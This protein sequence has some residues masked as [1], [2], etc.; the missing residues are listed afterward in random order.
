MTKGF[1]ISVASKG[2]HFWCTRSPHSDKPRGW[3]INHQ[4]LY[5]RL[6]CF[7]IWINLNLRNVIYALWG[8]RL[9]VWLTWLVGTRMI[10]GFGKIDD[11]LYGW[12]FPGFEANANI[13]E[14]IIIV[15]NS[16][17]WNTKFIHSYSLIDWT[18]L[19][20]CYENHDNC[21]YFLEIKGLVRNCNYQLVFGLFSIYF[22]TFR[23]CSQILKSNRM[24]F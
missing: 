17:Y 20:N 21:Q 4:W 19:L 24:C 18:Y 3:K 1:H 10:S 13:F 16:I 14:A 23:K 8:M 2:W 11:V 9:E 22:D 15:P 12:N 6:S 5:L 7:S